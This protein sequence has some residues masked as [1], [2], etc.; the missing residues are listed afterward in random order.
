MRVDEQVQ[1]GVDSISLVVRNGAHRLLA[2]GALIR[3]ARRLVVMGIWDE[4]RAHAQDREG[5]DLH[6]CVLRPPLAAQ[7]CVRDRDLSRILLVDIKVLNDALL[8]EGR[9]LALACSELVEVALL[10]PQSPVVD[11]EQRAAHPA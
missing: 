10:E 1:N 3:V 7:V 4:A 9:P 5:V 8:D 11:D 6:V 2:H